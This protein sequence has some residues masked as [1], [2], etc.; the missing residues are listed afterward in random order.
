MTMHTFKKA[1][2]VG[3]LLMSSSLVLST[4]AHAESLS[5]EQQVSQMLVTQG[6]KV[7][8]E[9]KTSLKQSIK[10][11]V[12]GFSIPASSLWLNQVNNVKKSNEKSIK[13]STAEE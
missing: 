4:H 3:L 1:A 9:L 6:K 11:E 2:M 13:H 12:D 8:M 10:K 7:M 5:L